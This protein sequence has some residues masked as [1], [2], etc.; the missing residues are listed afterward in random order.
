MKKRKRGEARERFSLRRYSSRDE[1]RLLK[2]TPKREQRRGRKGRSGHILANEPQTTAEVAERYQSLL[3]YLEARQVS[4]DDIKKVYCPLAAM[5][6]IFVYIDDDNSHIHRI[7]DYCYNAL[8]FHVYLE[9][10][11]ELAIDVAS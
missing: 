10:I 9:P 7:Q 3:S 2:I 8:G 5:H 4:S 6:V 1:A 11:S